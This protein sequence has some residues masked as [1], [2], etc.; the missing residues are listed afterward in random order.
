MSTQA[1]ITDSPALAQ[2]QSRALVIGLGGLVLSAIGAFMN[3]D[4]FI[5][6]WLIG[7]YF[8]L[9]LTLGSLALLMLQ[10]LSGGQWGMVSRRIFEAASRN[11][12]IVALFFLPILLRL[13]VLFEW[14]RPEAVDNVIIHAKAGYLNTGFFIVRAVIYF[15][16]WMLLMVLL[17]RWSAEQDRGQGTTPA[18]SVRFRTVSA[19]GMLF[20]V[21]TVTFASVDWIMS[22]DAEWFSTIFGLLTIAG[23]GLTAF[24]F[25]IIVLAMLQ[26][27]GAAVDVLKPRHFHDLGKLLLAFTMLWAYLSFSQFLIIWSGNLPEEIPWYVKRT[28]GSWGYVAIALVVGH[29]FL[30]FAAAPVAGPQEAAGHARARRGFHHRHAPRRSDLARRAG[31]PARHG[32]PDSL[33]RH[34]RARRPD[35]HLDVHV[36]AQSAQPGAACRSTTRTSRRRSRMKP[37][38]HHAPEEMHNDDTAHEHSDI[39]IGALAWS[40]VVM[41]GAVIVTAGLMYA[42]LQLP[43]S[44]TRRARDPKLSPLAMPATVDAEVDDVVAVFRQRAGAEADDRRA[45]VPERSPDASCRTSCTAAGWIDEKAG[46]DADSDRSAQRR[47]CSR[48]ACRF[49]RIR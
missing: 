46:V 19:P 10:H 36:R 2:F 29:F 42:A 38:S 32:I 34:H 35:R 44:A 12:P 11:L 20:L 43:R 6:S 7:F 9:G 28:T 8:C 27:S 48:T 49:V 18:D 4:Q 23:W 39:N 24:A 45:R 31:V 21:L 13:P 26:R 17:N 22:L 33:A 15:A 40:M 47:S 3:V 25:A 14:A 1:V 16:F 37:T 5:R 30:P 41:F